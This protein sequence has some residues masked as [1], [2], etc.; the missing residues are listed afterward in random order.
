MSR[1]LF[2]AA[3]GARVQRQQENMTGKT[4]WDD[5]AIQWGLDDELRIH[6][7]DEGLQ[8]GPIST[9]LRE[10]S[11]HAGRFFFADHTDEVNYGVIKATTWIERCAYDESSE[12]HR[13]LFL[14]FAAE[15][16]ADEGL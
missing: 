14:L 9:A 4:W 16:L 15:M 10:F 5:V 3:R 11:K 1:L 8:Y 2:A 6:P 13:A 12:L 7:N